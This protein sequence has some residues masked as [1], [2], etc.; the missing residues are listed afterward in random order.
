[1]K[2]GLEGWIR[3]GARGIPSREKNIRKIMKD[4]SVES[5]RRLPWQNKVQA[6]GAKGN[7]LKR[8]SWQMGRGSWRL[9][10]NQVIRKP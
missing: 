2:C 10:W 4:A 8:L 7:K 3:I 1:M 6:W 5:S 9:G